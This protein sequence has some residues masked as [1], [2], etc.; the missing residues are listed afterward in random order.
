MEPALGVDDARD[1]EP[2]L[3]HLVDD[4]LHRGVERDERHVASRVH[5]VGDPEEA[6][7]ELAARVEGG[8]VLRPEALLDRDRHREGVPHRELRGGGGRRREVQRAGL[9]ADRRLHDGVGLPPEGRGAP[10]RQ[11]H[12]EGAAAPHV[13]EE[14]DDLFRLPGMREGEYDVSGQD[15]PEVAVDRLGGV[16]EEGGGARRGERRGDLL[17]DDPALADAG[18]DDPARRPVEERDGGVESA[19][20]AVGEGADRGGL[21]LEDAAG[22]AARGRGHGA[23]LTCAR[24]TP[25]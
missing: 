8:E 3:R 9:L 1:P 10:P 11:R 6:L 4:V 14:R 19:V 24:R 18:D 13:G 21:D 7:A 16:E 5:Q 20:E 25:A 17:A 2:L 15:H 22:F 23:D 12:E